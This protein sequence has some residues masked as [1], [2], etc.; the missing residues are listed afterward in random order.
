MITD[1]R[2]NETAIAAAVEA[3]LFEAGGTATIGQ[4]RRALPHLIDL[5]PQDRIIS[6]TRPRE[7]IWEQQ[8]RNIVCHRDCEGN[9]VKNGRIIWSPGKLSLA[10]N[11][12]RSLF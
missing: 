9:P 4:I 7:E 3:Y 6:R 8:V 10:E 5:A 11:P 2:V 1:N 12:Q